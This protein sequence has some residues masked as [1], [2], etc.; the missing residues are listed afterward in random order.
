MKPSKT[1]QRAQGLTHAAMAMALGVMAL[2]VFVNVV[3]YK[4]TEHL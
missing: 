1:L 2:A 4:I 3:L